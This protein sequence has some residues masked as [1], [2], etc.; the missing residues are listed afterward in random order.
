MVTWIE[1]KIIKFGYTGSI[2]D[3]VEYAGSEDGLV[4]YWE[5]YLEKIL[6]NS[7]GYYS[8]AF[9]R[10]K[11]KDE[12]RKKYTLHLEE[13]QQERIKEAREILKKLEE[14][15]KVKKSTLSLLQWYKKYYQDTDLEQRTKDFDNFI[16]QSGYFEIYSFREKHK[17]LQE[18]ISSTLIPSPYGEL[19]RLFMEKS[20]EPSPELEV[21][22]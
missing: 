7:K 15:I 13:R 8:G 2:S 20:S 12:A 4:W 11:V 9:I 18:L 19:F 1:D 5:N 21:A 22:L 3:L 17:K 10:F 6:T 14:E 16:E